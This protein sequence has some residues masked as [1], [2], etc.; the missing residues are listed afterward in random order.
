MAIGRSA[1]RERID[2][3][4]FERTAISRQPDALIRKELKQLQQ[5]SAEA[6]LALFLKDPYLLDFLDLKDNFSENDL[7]SA[8]LQELERFI[9]E[10]GSDFAFMCRQ[11]RIHLGG[12][13]YYLDLLFYHRKL[14]RM[15]LIEL[16]LGEFKP[17]YKGQV[18]LYL[19]WLAKHEQQPGEQ[20][21]IAIILCSGKDTEVVEL[22]DLEPENIHVGE[23]WLKLPPRE[24][25]EAKL[26]KAM[27][28]ARTQLELRRER[29]G[30]E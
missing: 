29:D 12:H 14:K 18:E 13:D 20:S 19:K 17:D 4:L 26:R 24:L 5:K 22:L 7:E 23:Y 15:V 21:P 6:S 9:L 10:L 11:R 2:S 3:M 30:N 28:Q 8:I 27:V 1:L 25:L 16:K